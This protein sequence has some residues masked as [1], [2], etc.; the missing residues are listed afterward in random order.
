VREEHRVFLQDKIQCAKVKMAVDRVLQD[1]KV[2]SGPPSS[3]ANAELLVET[4]CALGGALPMSGQEAVEWFKGCEGRKALA[5]PPSAWAAA[6]TALFAHK[7]ALEGL[8]D[9][10]SWELDAGFIPE[11]YR[12]TFPTFTDGREADVNEDRGSVLSSLRLTGRAGTTRLARAQGFFDAL[13]KVV[14]LT[15]SEGFLGGYE[16]DRARCQLKWLGLVGTVV[17]HTYGGGLLVRDHERGATLVNALVLA[18]LAVEVR[19]GEGQVLNGDM[20]WWTLSCLHE[21]AWACRALT[22]L[23]PLLSRSMQSREKY[24]ATHGV[25]VP[26]MVGACLRVFQLASTTAPFDTFANQEVSGRSLWGWT[27]C[28]TERE[29]LFETFR[30]A[31]TDLM[32]VERQTPHYSSEPAP[33]PAPSV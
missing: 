32:A 24:E 31:C 14:V 22:R 1:F 26:A 8:L 29:I 16:C 3:D 18:A 9:R 23:W 2:P 19:P 20:A 27:P 7:E 11:N 21:V 30:T 15:Q 12:L 13:V 10:L 5:S 33:A 28:A 17:K 4:L 25:W 6:A